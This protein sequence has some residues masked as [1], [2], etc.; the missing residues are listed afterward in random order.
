VSRYLF[1]VDL[2]DAFQDLRP[3]AASRVEILTLRLLDFLSR[4]DGKATFF[5]VGDVA[6]RFP[7]LIGRILERG[8][9][10]GCHSDLHITLDRQDPRSLR[11]DLER[12]LEA[13][14]AAGAENIQGYR[15]PCFSLTEATRWAYPV[16]AD[17]GFS[18]SSSVLPGRNPLFGW[19][20]FGAEPRLVEGVLEMPVTLFPMPPVPMGGVYFRALPS[21]ILFHGLRAQVR[22]G[23]P[24]LSYIHPYD[25]DTE[26]Q[27]APHPGFS[28][29]S[30]YNWLMHFNR[31]GTMA[32]L[33]KAAALGFSFSSYGDHAREIRKS[34]EAG[35]RN[36][37]A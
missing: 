1:S 29:W 10:I 23:R 8:H 14:R 15:A 25:I 34:V 7:G 30:P 26:R 4:V 33:E 22:R 32:R 37:D 9:E 3:P 18:Y 31:R 24:V 21:P 11:K 5:V 6:R 19:P 17:L 28:R 16:L 35:G 20:G 36:G 2:E 13:L 12:N 27:D